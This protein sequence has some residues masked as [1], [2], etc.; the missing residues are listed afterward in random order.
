MLPV[1]THE[2]NSS[3]TAA[4]VLSMVLKIEPALFPGNRSHA[5]IVLS[6]SLGCL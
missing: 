4:R 5:T 6:G 1:V 2:A 3:V